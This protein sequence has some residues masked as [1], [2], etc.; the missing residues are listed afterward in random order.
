MV[1]RCFCMCLYVGNSSTRP[2]GQDFPVSSWSSY[3]LLRW[4]HTHQHYQV[5]IGLYQPDIE[6]SLPGPLSLPPPPS[7]S[8]SLL[9]IDVV[10]YWNLSLCVFMLVLP[11]LLVGGASRH[12]STLSFHLSGMNWTKPDIEFSL[13]V[14]LS[15]FPPL[16]RWSLYLSFQFGRLYRHYHWWIVLSKFGAKDRSMDHPQ[17]L[18]LDFETSCQCVV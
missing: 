15:L 10:W 18:T 2:P 14:P 8:V 6:L 16:L 17:D 13:P 3:D 7:I 11:S 1:L 9:D 12:V 5:W 4:L